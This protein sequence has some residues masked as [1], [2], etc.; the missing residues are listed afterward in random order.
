[1]GFNLIYCLVWWCPKYG[2]MLSSTLKELSF[3]AYWADLLICS[4]SG[5]ILK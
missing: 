4:K 2:I 3:L 1:M 5:R